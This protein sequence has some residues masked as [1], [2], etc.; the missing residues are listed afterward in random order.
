M[1]DERELDWRR[2][3]RHE[4][5]L[6]SDDL[7]PYVVRYWIVEWSYER[8]YRQL[9]VPY[10]NVHLVFRDGQASVSGVASR[11]AFRELDGDGRVLGVMFR[12]GRFRAFLGA[13]VRSLTDRTVPSAFPDL[14]GAVDVPAVEAMLRSCLPADPDPAAELAAGIVETI[15]ARPEITRVSVLAEET[16]RS[17]RQ[18]QR[19]FA[20][21]VG[22]GPKWVIRRYRLHEVTERM[23]A[24]GRIDWA[25]LAAGLGY[26]DQAHFVRD[27]TAMFG[28][29]PTGYAAR[30]HQEISRHRLAE[31]PGST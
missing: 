2:H 12:P 5:R 1:R 23:A 3:Q 17:P 30:Y 16:G 8:P 15:I 7:A 25:A 6:P 28:E 21:H 19:L 26:A 18:L 31:S 13:P 14:P 9:I 24:G 27:F 20:E 22:V 11:H 4:F 29:T 10:P